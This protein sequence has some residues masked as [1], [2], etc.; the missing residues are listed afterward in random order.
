MAIQFF[1][2][3]LFRRLT[4]VLSLIYI[5]NFPSIKLSICITL[6]IIEIIYLLIA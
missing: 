5:S 2:W 6:T 3:F 4:L 1:S